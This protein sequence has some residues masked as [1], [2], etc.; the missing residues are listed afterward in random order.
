VIAIVLSSLL[1]AVAHTKAMGIPWLV[2]FG[3]GMLYA[4]LR[5]QSTSAVMHAVIAFAMLPH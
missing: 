5:R 3:M 2:F 1:F 4:L